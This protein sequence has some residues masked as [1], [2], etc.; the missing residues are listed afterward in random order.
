M[1]TWHSRLKLG[2]VV[3]L[4]LYLHGQLTA[5][6]PNSVE[7]M[8]IFHGSAALLDWMLVRCCS[9]FVS[10]TLC[11]DMENLCWLS[12]LANLFGWVAYCKYVD[13]M[14]YNVFMTGHSVVQAIRLLLVDGDNAANSN[15]AGLVRRTAFRCAQIYP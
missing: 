12:M 1:N 6:L 9:N 13:G 10:G 8:L 14:Y 3:G 7:G 2:A 11:E 5:S 15:R 4:A